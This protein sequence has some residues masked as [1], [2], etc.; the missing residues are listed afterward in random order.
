MAVRR[1]G[2]S[3][4]MSALQ[5][6]SLHIADLQAWMDQAYFV[7]DCFPELKGEIVSAKFIVEKSG[8]CY[9]FLE[10]RSHKVAKLVLETYNGKQMPKA[11]Q[12]FRLNWSR[13][14][15]ALQ[16]TDASQG[17]NYKLV[18]AGDL[19]KDVTAEELQQHFRTHYPSVKDAEVHTSESQGLY[20]VI[21]F[22][23]EHERHLA[24]IHMASQCF[25]RKE[26]G[27]PHHFFYKDTA[28]E[29]QRAA[30]PSTHPEDTHPNGSTIYIQ[31][32]EKDVT[33]PF[34]LRKFSPYGEVSKVT[35]R[36]CALIQFVDRSSANKALLHMNDDFI[37]QNS[38]LTLTMR[39]SNDESVPVASSVEDFKE[40]TELKELNHEDQRSVSGFKVCEVD[41]SSLEMADRRSLSLHIA[42]LQAW[43]DKPYLR[44]ECFPEFSGEVMSASIFVEK[45]GYRYGFLEFRSPEVAELVR[46][47]YNGKTMPKACQYF[48]LNRNRSKRP[49][50]TMAAPE[51]GYYKLVVDGNLPKDVTAE[52]LQ[53]HF[54]TYYPSVKDAEVHTSESQGLYG[55]ITFAKEHERHLAS[56]HMASQCFRRTE[57]CKP[58]HFFYK[59]TAAEYQRA[60]YPSTHPEDTHPNGSTIYIQNLEMDVTKGF[61]LRKFSPYGEV[62]KI[63]IRGC[64]LI[65]FVDRSSADKALLHMND[66]LILQNSLLPLTMRKSNDEFIA[67]ASSVEDFKELT[68]LKELTRE[69]ERS[70]S[71]FRACEEEST[72]E[73]ITEERKQEN[74][75]SAPV[76]SAVEDLEELT[77]G[78]SPKDLK[79]LTHDDEGSV[80]GFRTCEE[81]STDEITDEG[82]QENDESVPVA[83]SVED[84]EEQK[85]GESPKD[86]KEL[87]HE[88]EGLVSGF[89]TCEE[90][91]TD[92]KITEEGKQEEEVKKVRR[93]KTEVS[94]GQRRR[95]KVKK[96]R[97]KEKKKLLKQTEEW[98]EASEGQQTNEGFEAPEGQ[99]TNE[100]SQAS[101]GH[102]LVISWLWE[103]YASLKHYL[104]GC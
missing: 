22:A 77:H 100:G 74:G 50:G 81:E 36:G 51:E 33:E 82:R 61:L 90:E 5:E 15:R 6:R 3:S 101:E 37:L 26:D 102:Q 35:I 13:P 32:L 99:Q 40:L 18:V 62:S 49:P 12:H 103:L 76:A 20:G 16:T 8:Y 47:T 53:Q 89:R 71:G 31:N 64:A 7:N 79:E 30:Y 11:C 39:K 70:V 44:D 24:S 65:Q 85:H 91:P 19:P 92:E 42:D 75:E 46:K 69:D 28:A 66:D 78:G 23:K 94:E 88:D 41:S 95:R 93:A 63:T 98:L 104:F 67:V 60:A 4:G 17:G 87:T 57:D 14:M 29:Y 38:L 59:D 9:G 21:T 80:S 25:R 45:S 83:S 73:K 68:E 48:R 72:D 58:H 10:F 27:K 97:Q 54:R 55:V 52:E 56:I 43:M 84:L 1:V 34:L 96:A 86:R 2:S